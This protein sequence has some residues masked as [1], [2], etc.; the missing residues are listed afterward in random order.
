MSTPTFCQWARQR[1]KTLKAALKDNSNTFDQWAIV[2]QIDQ[3]KAAI[4]WHSLYAAEQQRTDPAE[5]D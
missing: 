2:G 3:L 4:K 1:I 5:I